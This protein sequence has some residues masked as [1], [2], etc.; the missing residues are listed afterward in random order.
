MSCLAG[1][2]HMAKDEMKS[3]W[4]KPGL[5]TQQ[6]ALDTS[7]MPRMNTLCSN[8]LQS[9]VLPLSSFSATH[10]QF[11]VE[12]WSLFLC[13][14]EERLTGV[15]LSLPWPII[16]GKETSCKFWTSRR[17]AVPGS[18][19][20]ALSNHKLNPSYSLDKEAMLGNLEGPDIWVLKPQWTSSRVEP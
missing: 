3:E 11:P 5:Q 4:R 13:L 6:F 15:S 1:T 17:L 14:C 7:G 18:S 16:Y 19:L 9:W 20:S 12:R 8:L 2:I 10:Y